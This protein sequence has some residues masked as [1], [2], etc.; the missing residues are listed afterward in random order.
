VLFLVKRYQEQINNKTENIVLD[1]GYIERTDLR[2]LYHDMM[3]LDE[4]NVLRFLTREDIQTLIT[5]LPEEFKLDFET[6][7][8][9]IKSNLPYIN[10][11]RETID[12]IAVMDWLQILNITI[13]NADLLHKDGLEKMINRLI[14][15][16]L[17]EIFIS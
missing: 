8:A 7:E 11:K 17:D 2:S 14:D 1:K 9:S 16:M 12:L 10:H 13:E 6:S 5:R 4:Q 3:L 15:N